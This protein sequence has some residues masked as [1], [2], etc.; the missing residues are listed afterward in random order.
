MTIKI[1]VVVPLALKDIPKLQICIENLVAHSLTPIR[2]IYIISNNNIILNNLFIDKP[3]IW[4]NEAEFPF[5]K[6]DIENIFKSK[7][8]MYQHT[9]WYYQQLLKFYIF[10]VIPDLLPNTLIL[11]SDYVFIKDIKFLTDDGKAIL[12]S[13][14]PF[15]W[16]LNTKEYPYPPIHIHVSFA[17]R[18]IPK[19]F[20]VSSFSGMQHHMLFQKDIVEELFSIIAET[21]KQEFWKAF[22]ENIEVEKWNA[23]S[24]YVIYYHFVMGRKANKV[25]TRNLKTCDFIYD[26]K[27]NE[28]ML[29]KVKQLRDNSNFQAIGCHA[30]L[31]LRKRL[32]TMDYI[33][34][35]LKQRMLSSGIMAFKLILDD[36]ILQIEEIEFQNQ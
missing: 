3:L 9:S 32:E 25:I 28:L 10:R 36:G 35:A 13:G 16:L 11:D 4:V 7:Q 14:Y 2:N 29:E 12:A 22:V 17:T 19:W 20:P 18:F 26:S 34:S 15:K 30:F 31:D 24:E 8:C 6:E 21:H 27:E 23:A 33:P 1:D 5:T